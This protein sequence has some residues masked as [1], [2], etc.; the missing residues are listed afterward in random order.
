MEHHEISL[1]LRSQIP[2]LILETHEENRALEL[3]KDIALNMS[4]PIFK[5]SVAVGLQR[6]DMDMAP[7]VYLKE[8]TKVLEHINSSDLEAIYLLLDFH[9]FM[10]DPV[11]VRHRKLRSGP[12]CVH[13]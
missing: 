5:W 12:G 13:H 6:I 2:I 11:I 4:F 1:L 9:P 3:K 7:Q 8:P 10:E